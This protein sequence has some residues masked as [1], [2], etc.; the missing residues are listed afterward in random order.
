[1]ADSYLSHCRFTDFIRVL[2][3]TLQEVF[4]VWH[5]DLLDL[6]A[7]FRQRLSHDLAKTVLAHSGNINILQ[8]LHG[9]QCSVVSGMESEYV[10]DG[11]TQIHDKLKFIESVNGKKIVTVLQSKYRIYR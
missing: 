10:S 4:Q 2:S 5:R 9:F 1:M 3:D 6:L 7:E 11:I 8:L